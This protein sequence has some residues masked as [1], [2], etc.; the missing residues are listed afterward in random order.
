MVSFCAG[1]TQ[2]TRR[3]WSCCSMLCPNVP[4][5]FPLLKLWPFTCSWQRWSHHWCAGNT[6]LL[7]R[8]L[9]QYF[10]NPILVYI[11]SWGKE[12]ML[13]LFTRGARSISPWRPAL[14]LGSASLECWEEFWGHMWA[15]TGKNLE[16]H[17]IVLHAGVQDGEVDLLQTPL[18]PSAQVFI[19]HHQEDLAILLGADRKCFLLP[20][21]FV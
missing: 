20:D 18:S 5:Q 8:V 10:L 9:S 4:C 15:Q 13:N 3:K 1:L 14:D 6:S 21:C 12:T 2:N 19:F 11:S 16:S 17:R 7:D